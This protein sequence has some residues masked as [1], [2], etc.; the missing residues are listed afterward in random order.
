[1]NKF[2]VS[3]DVKYAFTIQ[4]EGEPLVLLHGFTGSKKTWEE[5]IKTW[6]KYFKVIALD[7]PGHGETDTESARTISEFCSDLQD[8]LKML[9]IDKAH[10][11]GYSMGG[12]IALSFAIHYPESVHTLILESA[13]PGLKTN[14]ERLK[15]VENDTNLAEQIMEKGIIHFTDYWENIPLFET[16]KQL[17]ASVR[18]KIRQE[19]L[20]QSPEGLAGS[21][22]NMGT[23]K[24]P[25]FWKRLHELEMPV[26]L[27][28]GELDRKFIDINQEMQQE[29]EEVQLKTC[30]EAGHCIHV[31]QPEKF[32][33]IV[34]EFIE[35][36]LT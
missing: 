4:G 21:L 16:Q 3:K 6:E 23:G 31:E 10:L 24:Q 12:R 26:L 2:I 33:K 18:D 9:K 30:E 19:R 25:S 27:V 8:I 20:S 34:M 32:V 36:K 22:V 11:L 35:K 29:I 14:A 5:C 17:T 28:V 7:L 1:M 13:S 15:R